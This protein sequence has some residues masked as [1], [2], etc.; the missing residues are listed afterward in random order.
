MPDEL[1][2]PRPRLGIDPEPFIRARDRDDERLRSLT[3][4]ERSRLLK[5]ACRA[6]AVLDRSRREQG[7]P[8]PE[9]APWPASTLA[10]LAAHA[11]NGRT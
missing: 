7:L 1:P 4:E 11:P 8:E 6:A 10:F 2:E 5:S 3:M 9:P